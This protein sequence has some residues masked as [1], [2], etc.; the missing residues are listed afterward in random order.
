[1]SSFLFACSTNQGKLREFALAAS[2]FGG[3]GYIIEPLPDI[4]QIAAPDETGYTFAENASLKASYYSGFTSEL[5][6][7]DD[8][9][10]EVDA[11]GG[12]PGVL[13]ARFA[14]PGASDQ[15]NNDLLL[16]RLSDLNDRAARF[17]CAI[18][19]ARSGECLEIFHGQV[20]GEILRA[21]QGGNGF[22]YDPLFFYPPFASS[23]GEVDT[24]QKFRVSHRGQALRKLFGYLSRTPAP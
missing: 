4:K 12:E 1:M 20:N 6:F 9:G 7:A 23:F 2:A 8:S 14:G 19:L 11:L 13:S 16:S 15:A 24:E 3:S 17:V 22:G 18:A 10:L 5:V 21:P